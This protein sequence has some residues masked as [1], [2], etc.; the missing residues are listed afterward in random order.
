VVNWNG[1]PRPTTFVSATELQAAITYADTALLCCEGQRGAALAAYQVA[2]NALREQG[3]D[4]GWDLRELQ[5]RILRGEPPLAT[6]GSARP[7]QSAAIA[8]GTASPA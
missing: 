2:R 4:P 1:S 8:S 7:S 5:H 6:P 3:L